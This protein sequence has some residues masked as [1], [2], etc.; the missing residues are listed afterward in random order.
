[1]NKSFEGKKYNNDNTI[2]HQIRCLGKT[3]LFCSTIYVHRFGVFQHWSPC[4]VENLRIILYYIRFFDWIYQRYLQMCCS[5]DTWFI[6]CNLLAAENNS[7]WSILYSQ[8]RW[9]DSRIFISRDYKTGKDKRSTWNMATR[10]MLRTL[11]NSFVGLNLGVTNANVNAKTWINVPR[12][13]AAAIQCRGIRQ[14]EVV[15]QMFC[16]ALDRLAGI[17]R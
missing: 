8:W 1:M 12:I 2:K 15:P 13:S 9:R 14:G 10:C 16:L 17:T 11:Y 5:H 7:V 3:C 6:Y 4:V